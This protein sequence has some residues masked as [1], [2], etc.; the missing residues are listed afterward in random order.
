MIHLDTNLLI[1]AIDAAH[2][3][4]AQ[5]SHALSTGRPAA[6][7]AV[8]W[9]EFRSKP[10]PAARVQALTLMLGSRIL[11][12][13]QTVAELAGQLFQ[14]PGIKRSQR[15]DTMIAACAIHAGAELA[16]VN[17]ADF[18]PFVPH[19]LRLLPLP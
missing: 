3:H 17:P 19:G 14:I 7:D 1:A 5:A 8:A 6:T 4:H 13:S 15:L 18:A 16:T 2:L 10:V 11:P 12:Y 9:T